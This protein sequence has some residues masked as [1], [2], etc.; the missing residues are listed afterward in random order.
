MIEPHLIVPPCIMALHTALIIVWT[1]HIHNTEPFTDA[2]SSQ[3][4]CTGSIFSLVERWLACR[5]VFG[6]RRESLGLSVGG[7]E[8]GNGMGIQIVTKK[9]FYN[10]R[11]PGN[12]VS[13]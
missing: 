7:L 13:M 10:P 4:S 11:L 5:I 2:I 6:G 9:L 1:H 12:L 8:V 3:F